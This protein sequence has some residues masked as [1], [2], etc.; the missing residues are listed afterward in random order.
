M[1]TMMVM[2]VSVALLAG[3]QG[4]R[5]LV[6]KID[7]QQQSSGAPVLTPEQLG[8]IGAQIKK[9]PENAK[10]ILEKRGMDEAEFEKAVRDV[11]EN[12]EASKKYAEAFK[13]SA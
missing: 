12:P 8:E 1:K 6:S 9:D 7:S 4:D 3:C 2:I 10:Q 13:K 11:T 5:T